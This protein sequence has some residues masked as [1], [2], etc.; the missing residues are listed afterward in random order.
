MTTESTTPPVDRGRVS[1]LAVSPCA[2]SDGID[3]K[4]DQIRLR[5]SVRIVAGIA[6]GAYTTNMQIVQ[7]IRA[8]AEIGVRSYAAADIRRV[9]VTQKTYLLCNWPLI[10]S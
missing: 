1:G 7:V 9:V 6:A 5:A 4:I 8:A 3:I 2:R 10:I